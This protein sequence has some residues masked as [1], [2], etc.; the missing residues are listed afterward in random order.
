[1]Q[2]ERMTSFQWMRSYKIWIKNIILQQQNNSQ[3]INNKTQLKGNNP[4]VSVES[5]LDIQLMSQSGN[6]MN[7]VL[8]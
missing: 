6:G 8:V 5:Q 7:S 4:G 1:M 3:K 2:M